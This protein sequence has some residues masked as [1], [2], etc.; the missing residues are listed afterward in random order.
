MVIKLSTTIALVYV[1]FFSDQAPG[2]WSAVENVNQIRKIEKHKEQNNNSDQCRYVGLSTN[3]TY[4]SGQKGKVSCF[5]VLISYLE[6]PMLDYF[7]LFLCSLFVVDFPS[8]GMAMV[9]VKWNLHCHMQEFDY[10]VTDG[11]SDRKIT[12]E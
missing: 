8:V 6:R 5:S 9:M 11:G 12:D 7:P 10:C 4:N 2:T 3:F 1:G